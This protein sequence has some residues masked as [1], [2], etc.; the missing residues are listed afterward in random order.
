MEKEKF[1]HPQLVAEWNEAQSPLWFWNDKLEKKELQR[2]LSLMT[3]KHITC[4]APHARSGFEGGYLDEN[5]MDAIRTVIDHKKE[6]GETMWL[7]DEFNWPAGIANGEVTRHEEFREKYLSIRSFFVPAN[8]RFRTQP[9]QLRKRYASA[10]AVTNPTGNMHIDNLF[11]FDAKTMEPL[12]VRQ[13]QPIDTSGQLFN[14]SAFDF[15][16]LR[17][18]DTIVYEALIQTERYASEGFSDPDYLNEKATQKFIDITYEA[19]AKHFPDA[20]GSVITAGFN[21]ETRLC[22]AFP[23]TDDLLERFEQTYGYPL[24]EHLP[25]LVLPGDEAGRTRCDYFAL[26]A[27]LYRDHYHGVL[28]RWCESHGIDYCPHLLAEECLAGHVRYSG[29]YLRQTREMSRPG[30][31]HLGKGIGSLNLRFASSAAEVYGKKGLVCEVFAASGW[32]L[33]AEE[34]VRMA[35]WLYSQGVETLT[36]HGFFYSIRDFRKDDWPPSQFFQWDGW[37]K[38]EQ[39]NAMCRRLYGMTQ[40]YARKTDL[41]IYHPVETFWLHYLADQQFT[42]GFHMGPLVADETA[43]N[44]DRDEQIL[45]NRM[46]EENRDFTVFPGDAVDQF[47]VQD[48][49]LVHRTTGQTY[50]TFVLPMC[51]VLPLAAAELLD[52]FARSG[53]KLAIV[54]DIPKYSTRH[55]E[56]DRLK[57]IF[58]QITALPSVI[59]FDTFD[60]D[61]LLSWLDTACPQA[62]KITSGIADCKKTFFGKPFLHYPEW[63]IDPYIHTGEDMH[64]ISWNTFGNEEKTCIYLINYTDQPQNITVT[65]SATEIPEIWDTWTGAIEKAEILHYDKAQGI[66]EL[67]LQLP[68]SYGVFLVTD[69]A[70]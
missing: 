34:Y 33:T 42:H 15:E 22:H 21:D 39:A 11:C 1:Q 37:D 46:Q 6:H 10:D 65:V 32:E 5:W 18:R 20:F 64:G 54:K 36:N 47:T 35:S 8:T 12:D 40:E 25:D 16:V 61:A 62:M 66:Y 17:D 26:V 29:D 60:C 56:D 24:E 51:E 52:Q 68:K 53:G 41:L 58:R 55:E 14:L 69:S 38:M 3:E 45:L 70:K 9:H 13:F 44:L 23:W 48:G 50:H 57:E 43:K 27:N 4:N 49:A 2:Q 59:V 31:D 19:Y 28:R 30:V 7:Y 67:A 63:V